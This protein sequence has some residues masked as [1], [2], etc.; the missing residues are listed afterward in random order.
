MSFTKGSRVMLRVDKYNEYEDDSVRGVVIADPTTDPLTGKGRVYVEWDRNYWRH[1]K[2]E[3]LSVDL[4]VSEEEGDAIIAQLEKEFNE[5]QDK[6]AL[7]VKEAANLL[8]EAGAIAESGGREL[9]DMH[10]AIRP[11]LNA[12]DNAG[13]RTSSFNC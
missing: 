3:E 7:K 12:M 9:S 11:L 13:W 6:V 2:Q 8:S 1:N 10:E 5:L 4:L